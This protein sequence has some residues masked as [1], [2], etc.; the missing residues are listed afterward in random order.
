M[1]R[2]HTKAVREGILAAL[3]EGEATVREIEQRM[4]VAPVAMLRHLYQMERNGLVRLTRRVQR[5]SGGSS[6]TVWVLA[7]P[8]AE[9]AA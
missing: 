7:T 9:R 8:Q 3:A 2:A 1:I 6:L 4:G 5:P